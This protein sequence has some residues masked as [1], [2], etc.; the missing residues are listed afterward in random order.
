M[1]LFPVYSCL[2]LLPKNKFY[3]CL[4]FNRVTVHYPNPNPIF[5]LPEFSGTLKNRVEFGFAYSIPEL[6]KTRTIKPEFSGIPECPVLAPSEQVA[7]QVE[8][9]LGLELLGM[10]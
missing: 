5:G 10:N 3:C 1:H 6:I 4:Q 9:P 7:H 2:D 8:C